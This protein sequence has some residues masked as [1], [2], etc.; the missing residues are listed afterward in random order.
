MSHTATTT[1][2][3]A[4]VIAW[5]PGAAAIGAAELRQD[6]IGPHPRRGR[7]RRY[8]IAHEGRAAHEGI[9]RQLARV[10]ANL[11]GNRWIRAEF[12]QPRPK[13]LQPLKEAI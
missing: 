5:D 2:A 11:I 9:E 8:R 3:G 12:E 13:S 4:A 1:E 6:P 7:H 10:A